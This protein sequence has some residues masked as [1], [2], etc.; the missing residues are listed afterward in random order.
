MK[1]LHGKARFRQALALFLSVMLLVGNLPINALAESPGGSDSSAAESTE[2]DSNE[3]KA[4]EPKGEQPAENGENN[5]NPA[6]EDPAEEPDND[7]DNPYVENPV[8]EPDG[9]KDDSIVENPAEELDGENK[10][11]NEN[12]EP[13][14]LAADPA[15]LD[16]NIGK[17]NANVALMN[18]L[19]KDAEIDMDDPVLGQVAGELDSSDLIEG[20]GA[21]PGMMR[22]RVMALSEDDEA[23]P[24]ATGL[25]EQEKEDILKAFK[26]Y[27]DNYAASAP[28]LGVQL[29]FFLNENDN[30]DDLGVLGEMLV[31]AGNTVAQVRNGDL[32]YDEISGMILT[33]MLGDQL[34]AKIYG[35]DITKL[36]NEALKAVQDSKAQT[37]AQK[38]LVLNDWLATKVNFD[39]SYIMNADGSKAMQ[40]ENPKKHNNHD[41]VYKA[42]YDMYKEAILEDLKNAVKEEFTYEMFIGMLINDYGEEAVNNMS[43]E[44]KDAAYDQAVMNILASDDFTAKLGMPYE[45]FI[46]LKAKEAADGLTPAILNYWEGSIFNTLGEGSAVCLGYTRAYAYLVQCMHPEIYLKAGNDLEKAENWKANKDL[47]FDANNKIKLD[48]GYVVDAVRISFEADVT[49][50]GEVKEGFNSDHFWNAVRVNNQ[51]YYIDPTYNDVYVE[52]MLRDRVET[53]GNMSH[54]Y[55][56]LSDDTTRELYDGYYE[57]ANG[58]RTL[59]QGVATHK[60]YED[61]WMVRSISNMFS[62]GQYFYYVYSSQDLIDQ[63]K[64]SNS[65]SFENSSMSNDYEYKLVR[66][67]ISGADAPNTDT[68]FDALIEFNYKANKDDKESYARVNGLKDDYLTAL[69]AEH[70]AMVEM[71]P[72]ITI[73]TVL[74]GNKLY[75]NLSNIILSYELGS[76]K[77]NV[78]KE[79]GTISVTRDK[80]IAFGGMSFSFTEGKKENAD[81]VFDKHPIAALALGK[82]GKLKVSMA[83]N[84]AYISGKDDGEHKDDLNAIRKGAYTEDRKDYYGYAFEETN[85]NPAYTSYSSKKYEGMVAKEKNDNDEFMWVANAVND[86]SFS[87][88]ASGASTS[89]KTF[90]GVLCGDG[91]HAYVEHKEIYFTKENGKWNTGTAYVCAICG[92]SVFEPT[93]PTGIMDREEAQAKYEEKLAAYNKAKEEH[94]KSYQLRGAQW[95]DDYTSVT[96]STLICKY[97]FGD[98]KLD[99]LYNLEPVEVSEKVD[100]IAR[101]ENADGSTTY[102]AAS[103]ADENY[104]GY[105]YKASVTVDKDGNVSEDGKH[106]VTIEGG[107][108]EATLSGRYEKDSVVRIDAGTKEGY[109]FEKWTSDEVTIKDANK[110]NTTFTMPDKDVTVTANWKEV[111][112]YAVNIEDGGAGATG[113]GD[114][115]KG[116]TVTITAGT[117]D[118]YTFKEWTSSDVTIKNAN[119][120]TITFTMPEKDVKVTALWTKNEGGNTGGGTTGGGTTGGGTTGGGT[121]GGGSGGG[122]GGGGASTGAPTTPTAPKE[123]AITEEQVPLVA[124]YKGY[125]DVSEKAWYHGVVRQVTTSGLFAGISEDFFGPDVAVTRGMFVT[126]LSR[127]EFGGSDKVP[128]GTTQFTDLTQDWY[129]DSIAWAT[130]NK[131]AYGTSATKFSPDD[132]ITREQMIVM[133]YRYAMYKGY[134]MSHR[135]GALNSFGDKNMVT[136]ANETAMEWAIKHGLISGMTPTSLAPGGKTTRAQFA[137][138]IT[139]FMD[140][141]GSGGSFKLPVF[142]KL[143]FETNG[144]SS[145]DSVSKA[146]GTTIELDKYNTYRE[147][148]TFLGWY[149]DKELKEKV[150]SVKLTE[151]MTIYAG[152]K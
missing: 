115:K 13:E 7:K 101:T 16:F 140:Y 144:G 134:D 139:R 130:A 11:V 54:L 50:Y 23:Q 142:H 124:P 61:S 77:V 20:N 122:G 67:K 132:S 80:T 31:L 127:V 15:S 126:I 51:W 100:D 113:Q 3:S 53:D 37:E 62:N 111:K 10:D 63:L 1:K 66:H 73:S 105:E 137:S 70:K 87:E 133:L 102:T 119:E 30:E 110:A 103:P 48:K 55:F 88:L 24:A 123:V 6:I 92:H 86:Y 148:H 149:A 147:G 38:L 135:A 94:K 74:K 117:K 114:Y 19:A 58:I 56:L 121:T 131:I 59:Y 72:S 27:L 96:F 79:M 40:A 108:K 5:G 35:G 71:Y 68:E 75:F 89:G 90:T 22:M 26:Q 116:D 106:L 28:V 64:E 57:K 17:I 128:R 150:T 104:S 12:V 98:Y 82:D 143:T 76:G 118:G 41:T 34:G 52:V 65:D 42:V 4:N 21:G 109:D 18:F 151:D 9:N 93:K 146:R 152:W 78:E 91:K 145:I 2:V 136:K 29:P 25:T 99:A 81:F 141:S 69:Y 107:G 43:Q 8:E 33:L 129:K 83:T 47:Y 138:I 125:K 84:L 36:R 14:V 44:E 39:M 112:K 45:E 60:D 97:S 49:M 46:D 85:F 120:K 32:T 95:A